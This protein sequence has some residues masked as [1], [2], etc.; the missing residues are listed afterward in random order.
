MKRIIVR[1]IVLMAAWGIGLAV[2]AQTGKL[3]SLKQLLK[4][5][6]PRQ[7]IET[8]LDISELPVSRDTAIFYLN[9]ALGTARQIH[10]DSIF[11]IQ[12]ALASA[13]FTKGDFKMA[14]KEIR[15]GFKNYQYTQDPQKTLGHIHMLLGA[16]HEA[17]NH[18]DSARYYY[19][20]AISELKKSQSPK[21][22]STLATAYTNYGN[23]YLKSGDYQKAVD[24]YMKAQKILDKKG[25][26]V[27]RLVNLNNIAGCLFEMKQYDKALKYYNDALALAEEINNV[28]YAGAINL[29]IGQVYVKKKEVD[30]AIPY[31]KK[32]E[33]LLE[34][35][36]FKRLLVNAY[37]NLAEAYLNIKEY[38]KARYYTDKA[39]Q[40]LRETQ[41]DFAKV[42][43]LLTSSILYKENKQ[44]HK[45]LQTVNNALSIAKKNKYAHL[46]EK[47]LKEKIGLLKLLRKTSVLPKLYDR[48]ISLRDSIYNEEKLKTINELDAKYQTEKK[49]KENQRLLAE[50]YKQEAVIQQK[51]KQ[52]ILLAGGFGAALAVAGIIGFFYNR[53]RRQKR[54]IESLQKD[55]HHRVKNNLATISSLVN[56]I[57]NEFDHPGLQSRLKELQMRITSINDVH[58]QLYKGDKVYALGFK[59]YMEKLAEN[60]KKTYGRK[61]VE[62][63]VDIDDRVELNP[64]ISFP[65]GLIVAEFM[66]NS[67]KHAFKDSAGRIDIILRKKGDKYF[68]KLRDNGPGSDKE[69][70]FEHIKSY[71][72]RQIRGLAKQ[73]GA[74]LELFHDKGMQMQL[75]FTR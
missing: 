6:T 57:Q 22:Q 19:D 53:N 71:G 28:P 21:G 20:S 66:S 44:Y 55:L 39:L 16:F 60:F 34:M 64:D 26:K 12:F 14:I 31:L 32:G 27:S 25:D 3:D 38:Q 72:M 35:A 59:D 1:L 42:S 46:E 48:Y 15:K 50:Q 23:L 68:L 56:H 51:T 10:F 67:F 37:Q 7:R 4:T 5:E 24:I 41:N 52:N 9:K 62:I 69:I 43:I 17:L 11:P 70:D 13:Y 47:C 45:A 74:S 36:G 61:D 29:G 63:H 58:E 73:I 40:I 75:V 54:L 33:K 8:Y 2:F 30:K 18:L 49:E 65:L